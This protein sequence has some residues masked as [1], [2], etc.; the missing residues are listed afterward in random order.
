MTSNE[1]EEGSGKDLS[2]F[3]F[4]FF[5]AYDQEIHEPAQDK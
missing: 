3:F 1:R 2:F 5:L 4:S